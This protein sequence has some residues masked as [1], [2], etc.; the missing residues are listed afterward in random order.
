MKQM[1]TWSSAMCVRALGESISVQSA[2]KH[3]I[4]SSMGSSARGKHRNSM[5]MPE[6]TGENGTLHAG[7][8]NVKNPNAFADNLPRRRCNLSFTRSSVFLAGAGAAGPVMAAL[9]LSVKSSAVPKPVLLSHRAS[10]C[11]TDAHELR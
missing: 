11:R 5:L 8:A 4:T 7:G 1:L 10:A 6:T 9:L 3:D 2:C